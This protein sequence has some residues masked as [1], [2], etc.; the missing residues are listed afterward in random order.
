[1]ATGLVDEFKVKNI[2][3]MAGNMY[4]WTTE[5]GYHGSGTSS[6]KYV[7]HRGGCPTDDGGVHPV[8]VRSGFHAENVGNNPVFGFR[9]VLYVK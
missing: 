3:D 1:M 5:Y 8:S 7:V 4:E 6:T 9:V 2:Y